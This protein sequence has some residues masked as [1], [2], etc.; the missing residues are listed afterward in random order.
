VELSKA[1]IPKLIKINNYKELVTSE[2]TKGKSM[3]LT[4]YEE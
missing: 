1:D 2:L 3:V 4:E